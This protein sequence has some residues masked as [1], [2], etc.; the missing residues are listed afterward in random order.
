MKRTIFSIVDGVIHH[1]PGGD[2]QR[3]QRRLSRLGEQVSSPKVPI[4]ASGKAML[5]MT[6][7]Q[8]FRRKTNMTMTTRKTVSIK[9][10]G[11]RSR[12]RMVAVGPS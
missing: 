1:E 6:V 8:N 12:T 3:H 2:G 5:G 11:H 9:V 7:A 4:M 10:S